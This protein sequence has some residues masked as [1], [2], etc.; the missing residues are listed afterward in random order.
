MAQFYIKMIGLSRITLEQV[1]AYWR[2]QV[3]AA[4]AG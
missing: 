2:A 3:V 1:P 4:M